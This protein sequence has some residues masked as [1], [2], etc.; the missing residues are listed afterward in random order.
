MKTLLG[1]P[2]WLS[3][4]KS[5]NALVRKH[6]NGDFGDFYVVLPPSFPIRLCGL[7]DCA[8]L[9]DGG[10]TTHLRKVLRSATVE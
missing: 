3:F 9:D 7:E 4:V 1:A 6:D 10:K 2:S 5:T 8:S